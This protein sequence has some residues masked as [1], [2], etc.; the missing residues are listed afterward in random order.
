MA[1]NHEYSKVDKAVDGAFQYL[2][3]LDEFEFLIAIQDIIEQR[4]LNNVAL[5]IDALSQSVKW[6]NHPY[7]RA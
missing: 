7:R 2:D 3:E 5:F 1:K 4:T 6:S